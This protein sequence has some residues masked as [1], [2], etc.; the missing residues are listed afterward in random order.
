MTLL[1]N[2]LFYHTMY[3]NKFMFL[4]NFPY[5]SNKFV[6]ICR[7]G[8]SF[9]MLF[10][11]TYFWLNLSNSNLSQHFSN[12]GYQTYTHASSLIYVEFWEN[13]TRHT[14]QVIYL[15]GAPCF[16]KFYWSPFHVALPVCSEYIDQV[17]VLCREKLFQ[18]LCVPFVLQQLVDWV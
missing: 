5:G 14:F 6:M 8:T 1:I 13:E 4:S 11:D 2:V 10:K 12:L 17:V 16:M 3:F 18:R 15:N 7:K 9:T